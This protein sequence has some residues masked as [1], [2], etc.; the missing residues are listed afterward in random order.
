MHIFSKANEN[1]ALSL[2]NY[3]N[4]IFNGLDEIRSDIGAMHIF[5]Y[6]ISKCFFL[7]Q[8]SVITGVLS[9]LLKKI[10]SCFS[11]HFIVE[12]HVHFLMKV[13]VIS[14]TVHDNSFSE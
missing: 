1:G 8:D 7:L 6:K 2:L 10:I 11:R 9:S 3:P 14:M 12:I 4:L 5:P 13:V